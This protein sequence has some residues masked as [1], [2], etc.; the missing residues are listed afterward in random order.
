[1]DIREIVAMEEL[2]AVERLQ[3]EVW[4]CDDLEILP[5]IHMIAARH[6]G[7]ILLGA[8][9]GNAL[10]GFVY[11]F[12]GFEGDMRVIHS[13]MLAVRD[14]YRDRGVGRALKLAQRDHA[15]ARGVTRITWTFDPQQTRNAN[16]NLTHLGVIA[17]RYLRDFYGQTTSPLHAGGTDRL[18]VTWYL[19]QRPEVEKV[20]QRIAVASRD[21]MR[22]EFEAAFASGL[23]AIRFDRERSEYVLGRLR[24]A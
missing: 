21:Q 6:V 19:H 18:W 22:Q 24:T 23:A 10:V 13:D 5:A 3:K 20:E 11:G 15:L 16:L 14:E 9:D 4:S 12:P 1:M 8:F 2:R 17:D 7:A